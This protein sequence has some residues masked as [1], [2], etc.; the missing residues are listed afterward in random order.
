MRLSICYLT[1]R[2]DPCLGWALAAIRRQR[3]ASDFI[4][5]VVVDALERSERDLAPDAAGVD[6]VVVASPKPNLWQGRHRVTT[7]DFWAKSQAANT[8]LCLAQHDYVAFLDDRSMPGEHWLAAI[9]AGCEQRNAVLAGAYERVLAAGLKE[10]DHR[11][12]LCPD[13]KISCGGTWLYGCTFAL[14]LEWAL[15][16]NGFEEGM[17]GLP[18]EDCVFGF[19]LENVGHPINFVPSL[20]VSLHRG[21]SVDHAYERSRGEKLEAALGRFRSRART[22]F[23]PDLRALRNRGLGGEGFPLPDPDARDWYNDK[24]I[25]ES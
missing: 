19:Q 4:E 10:T 6:R 9:R 22:E 1:A 24:P 23:T 15:E 21:V 14:P 25:K 3:K 12:E 8:A 7:R 2:R 5:L 18:Q 13:G 16:V 11:L 20:F 17:D